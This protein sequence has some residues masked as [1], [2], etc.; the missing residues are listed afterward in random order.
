MQS[1]CAFEQALAPPVSRQIPPGTWFPVLV[2]QTPMLMLPPVVGEQVTW[3]VALPQHSLLLVQRL[4]MILQP[5]PGWQM[6]TPVAAH[7]PQFLLQQAPQPLQSTPSWVHWPVPL[8]PTS[9]Q[10]PCVAPEAFEQRPPQQSV[11]RAQTSPG[12]MQND[13][14]RTHLPPLQRP[15]QQPLDAVQ[16]LPAVRQVVL[17]GWHLP[18]VQLPLQ[19][20]AEVVQAALSAVQLVALAHRPLLLSHW[21]LQQSVFTAQVAPAE[22]QLVSRDTH[23]LEV[24]SQTC[25][26]H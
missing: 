23:V 8:V 5:S 11:S 12:W 25:V 22:P 16:G 6:F 14:P 21:R 3:P 13:E 7:G 15:E 20:A 2:E 17:R 9:I 4:L 19:Q 1:L 24:A 10:T 26:Q 18:P